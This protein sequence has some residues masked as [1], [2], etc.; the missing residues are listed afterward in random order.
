MRTTRLA[1]VLAVLALAALLAATV[2][3]GATRVGVKKTSNG[4][5]F[6]PSTVTVKRGTVV[7]WRWKGKATHNVTG[8]GFRST[9]AKKAT[10]SHRFTKKGSFLII[11]TIHIAQGQRMTVRVR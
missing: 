4:Y 3:S 11:C 7:T 9:T 8:P 10:Y 1:S 2:A 6:T 5:R